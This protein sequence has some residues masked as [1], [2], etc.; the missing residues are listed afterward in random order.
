MKDTWR[1]DGNEL[2]YLK[3]VLESGEVA[4]MSGVANNN[5]E[6][7]FAKLTGANYG[8]TFNSGTSTLHAALHALNV[9]RGDEVIMPALTVIANLHVVLAQGAIPVFADVSPDDFN[10]D[11]TDLEKKVSDKTKAIMVVPLYGNPCRYD[12]IKKISNKYQI[13]VINDAAQAPMSRYNG[14]DIAKLF[15]ITSFSFDATKHMS[16]G[17]GGMITT[18]KE[19][20]ATKIRK[21]GCLGYKSLEAS[22]GRVR[23]NKDLFQDPEYSRHDDVG[24][25]YRMS[26]FQAAVG[27]AQ[28]EKLA[29]FVRLRCDIANEYM[30]VVKSCEFLLPQKV[31]KQAEHS[32]W[33]FVCRFVHEDVTWQSFRRAFIE[34]GGSGIYAA[35]KL[36][37]Q[38]EVFLNQSWKNADPELYSNYKV[39]RCHSAELIQ[40][41][42]MQFPLNDSCI[43]DAMIN[44]DALRKTIK[45]FS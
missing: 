7:K 39:Q 4:G 10:I 42:L 19:D 45:D 23:N 21:F 41:Q 20:T 9:A 40:P 37:Y 22:E 18:L 38:E 12:E 8:I 24:L 17:D 13:P 28:L 35:W 29:A 33:T 31:E 30:S 27:L 5:F 14:T 11:P 32:Y 15:D 2:R 1:F 6:R 26:E 16:T 43:G 36:L 25:N 34:N 44:V 3:Q